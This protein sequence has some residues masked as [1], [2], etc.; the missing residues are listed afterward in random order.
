[1]KALTRKPAFWGFLFITPWL[2]GF[3]LFTAGPMVTS[4]WLSLHKYDLATS[5]YV[6]GENYR[7]LLF[8][9]PI[10]WK[11]VRI[12][13]TY[14]LF[15]VP[16]GIAASLGLAM[17]LNQ[18]VRGLNVYRTLFY[19][20]SIVPA[21]ASAILWQWVFNAENGILNL[22]LGIFGYA[23][24]QWLQDER[25][26]LTAFILMGLW[27]AGG[28]RMIIFLAGLQ[29]ISD[30][31]YEAASLDGATAWQR[32][33]HVTLPLLSPVMFFNVIL[34]SIGA[35]QIFTSA[36]V[37]TNGGPNNASMFYALYIFR[38]AFEYFKFGKASAM[39]W[40]LFLLL[41]VISAVQFGLSKR[42]VHY[43]GEAK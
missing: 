18:K 40:L 14:A 17:L 19:L 12:T 6:G 29:G 7:R 34:G 9:D 15:S 13:V 3:L 8:V 43:E 28:A 23:G 11:S 32:F 16:L 33:R 4:L 38:N 25:Y 24:P 20:P 39:A 42:W 41:V 1:M 31:Y 21:V 26:T 35:F 37:M 36:Y 5:Q 2:L 30:A 22:L 10:F 27:G